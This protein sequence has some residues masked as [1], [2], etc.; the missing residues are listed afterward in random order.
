MFRPYPTCST[1][2]REEPLDPRS[3]TALEHP[4]ST[5]WIH[6]A[7]MPTMRHLLDTSRERP[8]HRRPPRPSTSRSPRTNPPGQPDIGPAGNTTSQAPSP[9]HTSTHRPPQETTN[10]H[11]LKE[12]TNH[13]TFHAKNPRRQLHPSNHP[14]LPTCRERPQ[15]SIHSDHIPAPLI[16]PHHHP[17]AH[18]PTRNHHIAAVLPTEPAQGPH[19][20][21]ITVNHRRGQA[22]TAPTRNHRPTR[23]TSPLHQGHP[24]RLQPNPPGRDHRPPPHDSTHSHRLP[25]HRRHPSPPPTEPITQHEPHQHS[26]TTDHRRERAQA[27]PTPQ[28]PPPPPPEQTSLPPTPVCESDIDTGVPTRP[29]SHHEQD[30]CLHDRHRPVLREIMAPADKGHHI[31]SNKPDNDR[32]RTVLLPAMKQRRVG[33]HRHRL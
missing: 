15:P 6:E 24:S 29:S 14:Q 2:S 10:Q 5:P 27:A 7:P 18:Q 12:S 9:L 13:E 28:Q 11:P 30:R 20:P 1:P 31:I 4:S 23:T 3:P 21:R 16:T 22:Q 32:S 19:R 8:R 33:P 25:G 26:G 17:P